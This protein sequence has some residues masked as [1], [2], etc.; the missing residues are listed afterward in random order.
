M[1]IGDTTRSKWLELIRAEYT[2]I[3]G[4][5]LTKAQIQRFWGLDPLTCDELIDALMA[6]GFLKRTSAHLYVRASL[7]A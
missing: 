2:E 3:P 5:N 4:L 1:L 7:G 6:D